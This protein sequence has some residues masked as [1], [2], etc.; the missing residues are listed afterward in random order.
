MSAKEQELWCEGKRKCRYKNTKG[1]IFF[2]DKVGSYY[3]V[4]TG[5]R[6]PNWS[7]GRYMKKNKILM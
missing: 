4:C 7:A 3:A 6:E 2:K 5:E 1:G